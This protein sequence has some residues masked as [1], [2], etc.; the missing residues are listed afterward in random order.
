MMYK[1][2]RGGKNSNFG[3]YRG[4]L[5]VRGLFSGFKSK[6][7]GEVLFTYGFV[8]GE[9][10]RL[11]ESYKRVKDLEILDKS[12]VARARGLSDEYVLSTMIKLSNV[13]VQSM[14]RETVEGLIAFIEKMKAYG[15]DPAAFLKEL[16]DTK[17]NVYAFLQYKR[18]EISAAQFR[19]R[20]KH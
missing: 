7:Q 6:L 9:L 10:L 3:F 17:S 16:S 5:D 18:G 20:V 4:G 19:L 8:D 13:G 15:W 11:S 12:E 2:P 14:R 1:E